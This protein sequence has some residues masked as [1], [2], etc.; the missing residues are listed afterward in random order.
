M[1]YS[2][3]LEGFTLCHSIAGGTGSG[4]GSY[5]LEAINDRFPKKLVQTYSVFPN[6]SE[7]SDVVVQ[8]CAA[9]A[10]RRLRGGGWV[11]V[12]CVWRWWWWMEVV[13][14]AAGWRW[15][16]WMV[17]VGFWRGRLGLGAE[18]ESLGF[19]ESVPPA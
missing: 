18:V 9:A 1:G 16:Q 10:G 2:D 19:E 17:A 8:V 14:G 13:I 7:S 4:M 3:S 5:L 12:G 15:R 11:A 6:Q